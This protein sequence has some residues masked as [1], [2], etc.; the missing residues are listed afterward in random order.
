MTVLADHSFDQIAKFLIDIVV[1]SW[2]LS[3]NLAIQARRGCPEGE[4]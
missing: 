1:E 3:A 4:A 2:R